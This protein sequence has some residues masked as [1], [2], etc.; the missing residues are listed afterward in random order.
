MEVLSEES[1]F[2]RKFFFPGENKVTPESN[3]SLKIQRT[4]ELVS[5]SCLDR[6]APRK[7]YTGVISNHTKILEEKGKGNGVKVF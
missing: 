2:F 5:S 4:S 7:Q 1:G 3:Y 6:N